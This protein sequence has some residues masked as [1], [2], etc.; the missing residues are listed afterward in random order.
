MTFIT[1]VAEKKMKKKDE[2]DEYDR[3][4]CPSSE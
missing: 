2:K 3:K 4:K 1:H